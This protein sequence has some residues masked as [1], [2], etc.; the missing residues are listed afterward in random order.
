MNALKWFRERLPRLNRRQ[1]VIRNL[2]MSLLCL[3]LLDW[4]LGF[5]ALSKRALLREAE[6]QYLL[7]GSE[8]L[9]TTTTGKYG[10]DAPHTLYARNGDLLLTM[11]YNWTPLGLRPW[12]GE[13]RREEDGVCLV[14]RQWAVTSY[15]AFGNLEDAVSAELTVTLAGRVNKADYAAEDEDA[16]ADANGLLEYRETYTA[17]GERQNPYCFIFR[18]EEHHARDGVLDGTW[19]SMVEMLA[20]S[21]MSPLLPEDAVLRLYDGAGKLLHEKTVPHP[22]ESFRIYWK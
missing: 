15:M 19:Q 6:Q 3:L 11:T 2:A 20:F 13:L 17:R 9:F 14:Q 16:P 5:P 10:F 1:R 12:P 4:M 22:E 8:L 18:L 21:P 7:E